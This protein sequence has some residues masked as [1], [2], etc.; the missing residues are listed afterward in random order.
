[1]RKGKLHLEFGSLHDDESYFVSDV[2]MF[3]IIEDE[4]F[5][6]IKIKK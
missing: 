5:E 4:I 6:G 3:S 1:M 2:I